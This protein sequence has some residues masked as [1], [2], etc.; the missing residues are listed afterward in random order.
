[1]DSY[2]SSLESFR[3]FRGPFFYKLVTGEDPFFAVSNSKPARKA[4]AYPRFCSNSLSTIEGPTSLEV[5]SSSSK[6]ERAAASEVEIA[7]TTKDQMLRARRGTLTITM[8]RKEYFCEI[9]LL[10]LIIDG[11]AVMLTYFKSLFCLSFLVKQ[12]SLPKVA[13]VYWICKGWS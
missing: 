8:P 9:S 3:S 4:L 13:I 10:L 2:T 5:K 7:N 12:F 1:M 6:G 11:A